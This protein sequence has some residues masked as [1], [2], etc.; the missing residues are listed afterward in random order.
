MKTLSILTVTF[1]VGGGFRV[2]VQQDNNNFE[3]W[4]WEQNYGVK[5]QM[6]GMH[7]DDV[8]FKEFVEL[9]EAALDNEPYIQDYI[10]EYMA[11]DLILQQQNDEQQ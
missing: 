6:F 10:D 11:E 9:V 5:T 1:D 8:S 4:L 7:T 3:A 2:D